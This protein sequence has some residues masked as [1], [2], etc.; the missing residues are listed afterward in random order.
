LRK[1]REIGLMARKG[2]ATIAGA[3]IND[4]SRGER[5]LP[6]K[7]PRAG[8]PSRNDNQFGGDA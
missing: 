4:G 5:M 1:R 3:R 2:N 6:T 7:K 8:I